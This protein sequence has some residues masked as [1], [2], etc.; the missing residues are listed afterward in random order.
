MASIFSTGLLGCGL[1]IA[2][3][4]PAL[5]AAPCATG[6]GPVAEGTMLQDACMSHPDPA[7]P[8]GRGPIF[9]CRNGQWFCVYDRKGRDPPP[10][11]ADQAGPWVWSNDKGLLQR[12]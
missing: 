9:Q 6:T 5:A 10:C 11:T 1:A 12:P 7:C 8:G 4:S 2:L 3:L